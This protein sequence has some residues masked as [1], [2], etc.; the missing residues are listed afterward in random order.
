MSTELITYQNELE[1]KSLIRDGIAGNSD[2]V[3]QMV[4]LVRQSAQ[5][6]SFQNFVN[7]LLIENGINVYTDKLKK[8]KFVDKYIKQ[9]VKYESDIAGRIESIKSAETTLSDGYGDCDD[10]SILYASILGVLGFEPR[11]VLA[12]YDNSESQFSHIYVDLVSP[13]TERWGKETRFVFD[14]AIPYGQFNAEVK[15]LKTVTIDIFKQN[16]TDSFQGIFRQITLG[17]KGLYKNALD[18]VPTLAGFSPI[19]VMSYL[20]LSTGAGVASAGLNK[21]LSLNELGS[22]I[23]R[24]LDEIIKGLNNKQITYDLAVV[25]SLQIAAQLS[26]YKITTHSEKATYQTIKQ[27]IQNK[28]VYIENFNKTHDYN[29]T[30][31]HNG[32]ML[33]GAFVFGYVGYKTYQQLTK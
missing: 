16:E 17:L 2:I 33:A 29:V 15:P 3:F 28:L 11:F 12:I 21:T 1:T 24:Q 26:G 19:G 5:S 20:A 7:K 25:S 30:L 32:M 4:R 13:Y 9:H 14:A 22:R 31:N 27:S 8:L 18:V 23:H 10:L 6:K